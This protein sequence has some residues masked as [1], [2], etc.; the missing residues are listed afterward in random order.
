MTLS[1]VNGITFSDLNSELGYGSNNQ[2]NLNDTGVRLLLGN[3]SSDVSMNVA[4][5]RS[6][7]TS[8]SFIFPTSP[9][10]TVTVDMRIH[11]TVIDSNNIMYMLLTADRTTG[12]VGTYPA[13]FPY[14]VAIS[15]DM[16]TVLWAKR[17]STGDATYKG[18]INEIYYDGKE[19]NIRLAL[20]GQYLYLTINQWPNNT[21]S[22]N[23]NREVLLS[24][25]NKTDGSAVWNYGVQETNRSVDTAGT[26]G[27]TTIYSL[28][29]DPSGNNVYL[30]GYTTKQNNT[31]SN[32][33]YFGFVTSVN[34]NGTI[35]WSNKFGASTNTGTTHLPWCYFESS[36]VDS[37]SNVYVG[38]YTTALTITPNVSPTYYYG[39]VAKYNSAGTF[40][41]SKTF[42]NSVSLTG[43]QFA[44][45]VNDICTDSNNNVYLMHQGDYT[46]QGN[47]NIVITSWTPAGTQRWTS[48][49]ISVEATTL[50]NTYF[51]TTRGNNNMKIGPDSNL[52][53][54]SAYNDDINT[55]ESY[56]II[57]VNPTTGA[58][59]NSRK[60]GNNKQ[61]Q[62]FG[63]GR[64]GDILFDKDNKLRI[65]SEGN[66]SGVGW[67]IQLYRMDMEI[68]SSLVGPT[69][70]VN[71]KYYSGGVT[72]NMLYANLAIR[73]PP[74]TQQITTT[75]NAID[76][77]LGDGNYI[78]LLNPFT[79][80]TA[81]WTSNTMG[82]ISGNRT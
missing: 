60:F 63:R 29:V 44:Y 55:Y 46:F 33:Q 18:G 70:N 37:G 73:T 67:P 25:L 64:T 4:N 28:K 82:Y 56:V 13:M 53:L 17:L 48:P 57:C 9:P 69:G 59:I 62:Q 14:V 34:A 19:Q 61:V 11:S 8:W 74:P 79:G 30:T 77:N 72:S 31:D 27:Q 65:I 24:K 22:P 50:S 21:A 32:L 71:I 15:S 6:L 80:L 52:W 47:T 16:T 26:G 5:G 38:G 40:Q 49:E 7:T 35:Q 43:S 54:S 58:Y 2:I 39:I 3:T 36:G 76:G 45:R 51:L 1:I 66:Q 10:G 81:A 12:A 23:N 78:T 68:P 41:W 20:G 42:K 75:A